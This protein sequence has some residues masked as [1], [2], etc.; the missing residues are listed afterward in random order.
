MKR[1]L[2]TNTA[3]AKGG[4]SLTVDR[5]VTSTFNMFIGVISV[6]LETY[7]NP[8]T[9][10]SDEYGK[11]FNQFIFTGTD[12]QQ[13][14]QV[15]SLIMSIKSAIVSELNDFV[16]NDDDY[17]VDPFKKINAEFIITMIKTKIS[18]LP[19]L[20]KKP[21]LP[22]GVRYKQSNRDSSSGER[23]DLLSDDARDSQQYK[24]QSSSSNKP[25][26]YGPDVYVSDN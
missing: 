23:Y 25:T 21:V 4:S 19:R 1:S 14:K 18:S 17:N 26:T 11:M 3:K 5:L 7:G 22:D 6:D 24:S 16:N 20:H 10:P 9:M 15:I 12:D 8:S 13:K 2:T